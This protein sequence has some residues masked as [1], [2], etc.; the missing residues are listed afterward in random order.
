MITN[1]INILILI[2]LLLLL[3]NSSVIFQD[4]GVSQV[5]F[6]AGFFAVL[7]FA[8]VV[9]KRKSML[10]DRQLLCIIA[11]VPMGLLSIAHYIN[12]NVS[13]FFEPSIFHLVLVFSP[14]I[15]YV[16]YKVREEKSN[17]NT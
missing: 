6:S 14:P 11:A 5:T 12:D 10:K 1:F 8:V 16:W 2:G 13:R 17:E 15:A 3:T 9:V 7:S 4:W